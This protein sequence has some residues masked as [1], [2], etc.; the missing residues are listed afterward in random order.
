MAKNADFVKF[1]VQQ[2]MNSGANQ[3]LKG[4]GGG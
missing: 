2:L 1:V 4:W 3:L